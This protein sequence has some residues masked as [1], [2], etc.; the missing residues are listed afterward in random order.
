MRP[1]VRVRA[2]RDEGLGVQREIAVDER[3]PQQLRHGTSY[4]VWRQRHG[5]YGDQRQRD[6]VRAD[7]R[8][9][10]AQQPW[11]ACPQHSQ[12]DA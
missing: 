1:E 5:R 11:G 8:Q 7:N 9:R 12:A 3:R 10:A 2:S 6:S 4:V